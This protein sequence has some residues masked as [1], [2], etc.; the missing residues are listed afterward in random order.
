MTIAP[1]TGVGSASATLTDERILMISSDGHAVPPMDHYKNYMPAEW[2]EE[3]DAFC[4][5][6]AQEGV[7]S[8]E[9][10]S[11]QHRTD[12]EVVDQWAEQVLEP[13]RYEGLWDPAVRFQ[14]MARQG[15]A[16]DVLFPDFGMPFDLYNPFVAAVKGYERTPAQI[17]VGNYAHNRWLAEFCQCAPERFAGLASVSF[18]D[19]DA[20]IAEIKWAKQAGLRGIVLPSF[21]DDA[22][23]FD[24]RFDP[25]WSLLADYEMPINSHVA[26]SATTKRIPS[27]L[28]QHVPHPSVGIGIIAGRSFFFCHEVLTHLIWGGVLERHPNLQVVLTEQGSGWVVSTLKSMDYSW[29][30]SYAPGTA[31]DII[32]LKPSEYFERQCHL[33]SSLWSLAEARARHEIGVH[34]ITIGTDYPH[35]EGTWAAGP[36]HLQYLQAT[37]GVAGATPDEARKMLGENAIPLWGFDSSKLRTLADRIGLR[38]TDVLHSPNQDYYPR[39][40]V[41]KP[42]SMG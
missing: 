15:I 32:K 10:L 5:V 8:Y 35:L 39:G 41:H 20:T 26:I 31:R 33:G 36:G 29:R 7:R 13:R 30:G 24:G 12:P 6:H 1:T 2:R 34:K 9:A 28:L 11:L 40:D 22:P 37:L 16:A 27:E 14:E 42:L 19:V 25:V 38:M 23:I 21:E 18:A 4:K 3:F 17:E